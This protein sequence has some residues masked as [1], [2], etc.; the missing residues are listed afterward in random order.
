MIAVNRPAS[1]STVTPS[2]ARTAVPPEPC[3]LVAPSA[4]AAAPRGAPAR[5]AAAAGVPARA[6]GRTAGAVVSLVMV[7]SPGRRCV[8]PMV[9]AER[10]AVVGPAD[11]PRL[12]RPAQPRPAAYRARRRAAAATSAGPARVERAGG[13]RLRRV[14]RRRPA[15]G[16]QPSRD[17]TE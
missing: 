7:A 6:A 9:A 17:P 16:L 15:A 4:R 10:P 13:R 12:A 2:S 8:P 3:T 14:A 11:A 5:T 1:T